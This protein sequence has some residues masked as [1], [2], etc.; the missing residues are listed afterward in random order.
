M[1]GGRFIWSTT[2]QAATD[3]RETYTGKLTKWHNGEED[4]ILS[5]EGTDCPLAKTIKDHMDAHGRYLTVRYWTAEKEMSA[6]ELTEATVMMQFG[7]GKADYYLSYSE[8]TGYLWTTEELEVGGHDLLNELKSHIGK[9]LRLEIE[10]ARA[11]PN[12]HVQLAGGVDH[13]DC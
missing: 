6:D 13:E 9:W 4:D 5:L 7:V 10:Y 1:T 11:T 12:T 3:V 8:I 2:P